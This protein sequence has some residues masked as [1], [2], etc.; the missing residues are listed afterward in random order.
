MAICP[1][2]TRYFFSTPEAC[3]GRPP[4]SIQLEAPRFQTRGRRYSTATTN[5]LK[6][7]SNGPMCP[8]CF[9]AFSIMRMVRSASVA[10]HSVCW[11]S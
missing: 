2:Q 6:F 5:H 9:F 10:G 11:P 4:A 7:L 3:H 8:Y 1:G